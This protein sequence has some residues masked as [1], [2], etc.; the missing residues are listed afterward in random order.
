M[1]FFAAQA[2]G[3]TCSGGLR[4]P[5]MVEAISA[6]APVLNCPPEPPS[7]AK[8]ISALARRP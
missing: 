4:I 3:A 1:S 2:N 8:P 7:V 5:A 6:C